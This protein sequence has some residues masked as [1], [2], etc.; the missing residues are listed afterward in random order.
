MPFFYI[1]SQAQY[2]KILEKQ[3][4]WICFPEGFVPF[5]QRSQILSHS[6]SLL[7]FFSLYYLC[8]FWCQI[9]VMEANLSVS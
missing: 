6:L 4:H 2:D 1:Q 3:T 5:P 7:P 9:K 8:P